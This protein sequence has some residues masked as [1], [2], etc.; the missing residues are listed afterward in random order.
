MKATP[1]QKALFDYGTARRALHACD[2]AMQYP[3]VPE[4][5]ND[6]DFA[7][8]F[9]EHK[10]SDT[11]AIVIERETTVTAAYRATETDRIRDILTDIALRKARPDLHF[12]IGKLHGG[13]LRGMESLFVPLSMRAEQAKKDGKSF[14][15]AGHSLGAAEGQ[16]FANVAQNE[17]YW[18]DSVYTFGTPRSHSWIS[19]ARYDALLRT[20]TF[21]FLNHR[22]PVCVLPCARWNFAHVGSLCYFDRRGEPLWNP[23]TL[24]VLSDRAVGCIFDAMRSGIQTFAYHSLDEYTRRIEDSFRTL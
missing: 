24:K 11:Q 3:I 19:A 6:S 8:E 14:H 13:F 17:G 12:S 20:R 9:Y 5:E 23:N 10:E 22:D 15:V 18:I 7:A 21:S 4:F 1:T 16:I 2:C